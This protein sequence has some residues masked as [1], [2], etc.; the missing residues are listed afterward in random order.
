[1][2]AFPRRGEIYWIN[3][4]QED[5]ARPAVVVSVD[6]RNRGANDIIVVPL[7]TSAGAMGTHVTVE[8][9][10]AG[11]RRT[12]TAK[13]E[14]LVT[15]KKSWIVEGPLGGTIDSATMHAI[16]RALQRAVG[17]HVE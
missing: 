14:Q 9:G 5:Y 11:L 4:P 12:S 7:S 10:Q 13:S 1:M 3:L 16:E 2:E 17:I 15:V 8:A 6:H